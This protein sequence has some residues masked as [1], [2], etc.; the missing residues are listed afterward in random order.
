VRLYG[1]AG[2]LVSQFVR[3][4]SSQDV[5]AWNANGLML[6]DL[7]RDGTAVVRRYDPSTGRP[8][9][10]LGRLPQVE[11]DGRFTPQVG[12]LFER[13]DTVY[14]PAAGGADTRGFA[15]IW[16]I[17]GGRVRLLSDAWS[18]HFVGPQP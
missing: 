1:I 13:G 4:A 16:V 2:A 9:A 10:E 7:G 5:V 17:R 3:P 11:L 14:A 15:K 18:M 8:T 6:V 12:Q